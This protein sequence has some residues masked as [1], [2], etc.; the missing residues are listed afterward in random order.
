MSSGEN[1]VSTPWIT[2][3]SHELRSSATAFESGPDQLINTVISLYSPSR[4]VAQKQNSPAG[5]K[6]SHE[7]LCGRKESVTFNTWKRWKS[8]Q[9]ASRKHLS[10]T[11]RSELGASRKALD[12]VRHVT[13]HFY[14]SLHS[15]SR[16][17]EA[18]RYYS[19]SPK[20]AQVFT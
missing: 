17:S 6:T 2:S 20:G 11:A 16:C 3:G 7:N 5:K 15:A 14:V 1:Q 19:C 10:E 13:R 18:D 4:S 8:W 9:S 12:H